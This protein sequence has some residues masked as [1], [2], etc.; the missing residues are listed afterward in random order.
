MAC[1][2]N[3]AP[4]NFAVEFRDSASCRTQ[5]DLR[6]QHAG[7]AVRCGHEFHHPAEV[8]LPSR[9]ELDP[10]L[11]AVSIGGFRSGRES[12]ESDEAVDLH[13]SLHGWTALCRQGILVALR[14]KLAH[15]AS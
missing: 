4:L 15:A 12:Q 7:V 9:G 10:T 3:D 5:V 8:G 2:R 6:H 14:E 11:G 1:A 13:G